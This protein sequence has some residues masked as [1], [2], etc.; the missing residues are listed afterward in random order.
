MG[1]KNLFF[2]L[3]HFHHLPSLPHVNYN[4]SYAI[5]KRN[6]EGKRNVFLSSDET[7]EKT[8]HEHN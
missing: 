2:P 3:Y 4:T 7:N 8:T 1:K 5:R 6:K